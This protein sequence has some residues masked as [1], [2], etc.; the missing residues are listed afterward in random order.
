M[1]TPVDQPWGH[2]EIF[3]FSW[4]IWETQSIG[5]R[6]WETQR[7]QSTQRVRNV[8]EMYGNVWK[9][10]RFSSENPSVFTSQGASLR[11]PMAALARHP[12]PLEFLLPRPPK[13]KDDT[14]VRPLLA[15][16]AKFQVTSELPL[17]VQQMQNWRFKSF[18]YFYYFFW[19]RFKSFRFLALLCPLPTLPSLSSSRHTARC[20]PKKVLK[21]LCKHS[22]STCFNQCFPGFQVIRVALQSSQGRLY[23]ILFTAHSL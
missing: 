14:P 4:E 2:G 9:P 15:P 19:K 22:V 1:L 10:L 6:S 21:E 11:G 23:I 3:K 18:L 7:I 12:V 5:E 13:P 8:L 20:L 17:E 16:R